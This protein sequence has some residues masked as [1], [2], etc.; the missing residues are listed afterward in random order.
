MRQAKQK[1]PSVI[2][3]CYSSDRSV[4]A[5][6]HAASAAAKTKYRKL[7]INTKKELDLFLHQELN[8]KAMAFIDTWPAFQIL[9]CNI[10]IMQAY[11]QYIYFALGGSTTSPNTT[12]TLYS[13][14]F[15]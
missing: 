9:S 10:L 6:L 14:N 13:I 12:S 8:A 11:L 15:F 3:S 2:N 4:V 1:H 5:W 7:I